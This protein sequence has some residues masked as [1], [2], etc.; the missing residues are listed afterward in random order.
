MQHYDN[1]VKHVDA[2][3][4]ENSISNMNILLAQLSHDAQLTQE[5]R[6]EQQQR[7]RKAIFKHHES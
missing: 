1:I 4:T 7:L 6:F 2:L 5:Q 3:L